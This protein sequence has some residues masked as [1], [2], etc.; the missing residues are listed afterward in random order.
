M[1]G[2]EGEGEEEDGVDSL[3]PE[4]TFRLDSPSEV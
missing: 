3:G 2:G 4:V 1:R